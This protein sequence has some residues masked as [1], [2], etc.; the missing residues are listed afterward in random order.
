MKK[1]SVKVFNKNQVAF[2]KHLREV[3]GNIISITRKEIIELIEGTDHK[4]PSWLV[5]DEAYRLERGKYLIP[6]LTDTAAPA[7]VVPAATPASSEAPVTLE[8]TRTVTVEETGCP[9]SSF[10]PE[11]LKEYV[12]FGIFDTVFRII[13]SKQFLPTYITGH[14]GNGKTLSI[15]QSAALLKRK[16]FIVNIS[17]ETDEDDLLG[18]LRIDNGRTYLHYGPV[19]EAMRQGAILVLDE[20]DYGSEKLACLQRVLEGRS[21]LLKKT[22][23]IVNPAPGFQVFATG[24]TKGKGCPTG[25]YANTRIMNEAL[26]DRFTMTLEQSYPDEKIEIKILESLSKELQVDTGDFC[27]NLVRWAGATRLAFED[28]TRMEMISTRRLCD[29]I[30]LFAVVRDRSE[31]IAL[32]TNRFE[33]ET[34]TAFRSLYAKLDASV[35]QNQKETAESKLTPSILLDAS[36]LLS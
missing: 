7:P 5:N 34:Q 4:F 2:L 24:N 3:R 35:N 14:S 33:T 32:A 18:G 28:S 31:S 21:V 27:K 8:I 29:I 23:E 30:R 36:A 10:V 13:K 12:P 1:E 26:L 15:V 11:P 25:R 19:T 9:E 17:A 16:V 20:I 22:T 6:E